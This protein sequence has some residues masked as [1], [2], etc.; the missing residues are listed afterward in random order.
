MNFPLHKLR[1]RTEGFLASAEQAAMD[2]T[3]GSRMLIA[4]AFLATIAVLIAVVAL[5]R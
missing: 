3:S 1:A 4:T 2:I 5:M